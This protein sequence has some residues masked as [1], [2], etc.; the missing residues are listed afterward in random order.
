MSGYTFKDISECYACIQKLFAN[1]FPESDDL[2]A[3]CAESQRSPKCVT[4]LTF[5]P[6]QSER[7]KE[8]PRGS[9]TLSVGT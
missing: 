7:K 1:N 4:Q 6:P 8:E 2:F 9:E 3:D 5:G